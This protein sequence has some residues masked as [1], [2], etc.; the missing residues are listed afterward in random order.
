MK[1]VV[2]VFSHLK[3]CILFFVCVFFTEVFSSWS[4]NVHFNLTHFTPAW[5]FVSCVSSI[6]THMNN[7]GSLTYAQLVNILLLE[8]YSFVCLANGG[9]NLCFLN[10]CF[11]LIM[12]K[13]LSNDKLLL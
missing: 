11:C 1:T 9:I 5:Y 13:N 10:K 2:S 8:A 4:I 12:L 3:L 6:M 7:V